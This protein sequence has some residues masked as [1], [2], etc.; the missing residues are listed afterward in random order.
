M[1]K[2]TERQVILAYKAGLNDLK[3]QLAFLYEK[4]SANGVLSYAD[5]AKYNRLSTAIDDM[6]ETLKVMTK[7][8]AKL[9]LSSNRVIFEENFYHNAFIIEKAAQA[10]L[11]FGLLNPKVVQASIENPIAGLTLS[12]TLQANRAAIIVKI[13][14]ELTQGVIK[15]ESYSK[16]AKRLTTTLGNDAAKANRVVRTEAHRNASQARMY[17]MEHAA[18]HGVKTKKRWIATLDARTRDTHGALDGQTVDMDGFFRSPSG[19]T[20][21]APGMFGVPEED[22]NC[23][24]DMMTI[25]EGFEPEE[26]RAGREIIPYQTY[27]EWSKAK[28][29]PGG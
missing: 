16:I 7:G 21:K 29:L 9:I 3:V 12:E 28:G 26:R 2:S 11:S 22:I 1:T 18:A 14:Q 13:K 23:R 4:Y 8:N 27:A 17:S 24:C 10:K 6:T 20:A 19:A 25:I 5:M 15:G